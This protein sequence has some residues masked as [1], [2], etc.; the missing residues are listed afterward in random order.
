VKEVKAWARARGLQELASDCDV[1]NTA[2]QRF[3]EALGFAEIQRSICFRRELGP[4][5]EGESSDP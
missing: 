1:A 4:E 2:S 3:H 5:P